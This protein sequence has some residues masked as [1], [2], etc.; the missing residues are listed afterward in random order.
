MPYVFVPFAVPRSVLIPKSD[1]CQTPPYEREFHR[2][3]QGP[4]QKTSPKMH[5]LCLWGKRHEWRH[6]RVPEMMFTINVPS[7]VGPIPPDVT[8]KSYVCTI[9]RLA[10]M[11]GL[12]EQLRPCNMNV[13]SDART[14]QLHHLLSLLC[15]F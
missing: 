14:F 10:S 11:L 6:G 7:W 1:I 8:T 12:A 2:D 3:I 4:D 5:M 13:T 15:V 9:L